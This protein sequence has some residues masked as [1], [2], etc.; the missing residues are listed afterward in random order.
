VFIGEYHHNIDEKGRVQVPAKWR[1]R[2]A[3]GA[4]VT[5]GFDGS[6]NLYPLSV[7]SEIAEKLAALPQSQ[8]SVRAYVRQ[9]LAGAVDVEVD[10]LGRIVVPPLL[11]G[12]A[13]LKKGLVLA[14]LHDHIELWDASTWE[15]YVQSID[16]NS[17][18]LAATL[19]GLGL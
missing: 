17:P 11:K 15:A 14:G 3:E 2:L 16:G 1:S 9:T 12:Y 10:K 4:V 6:L 13:N 7:W 18:E 5:K 19:Q 8:P